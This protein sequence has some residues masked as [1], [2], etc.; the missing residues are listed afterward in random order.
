MKIR[1]EELKKTVMYNILH[2][3]LLAGYE[4]RVNLK[5]FKDYAVSPEEAGK[6][7]HPA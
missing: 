1:I 7:E 5:N 2:L 6:R 4:G 3:G